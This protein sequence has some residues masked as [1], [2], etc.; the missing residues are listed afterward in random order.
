MKKMMVVYAVMAMV[1][2]LGTAFAGDLQAAEGS[3]PYN[4]V[5]YFDLG[6][7]SRSGTAAAIENAELYNGVTYFGERQ[8]GSEAKGYGAGGE[9]PNSS[10]KE[11]YNGVTV[12][13]QGS[14]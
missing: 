3:K 1:L 13:K 12:F 9:Q 8:T 7:I 4:G 5:T 2:S 11:F 6:H 10:A 14:L